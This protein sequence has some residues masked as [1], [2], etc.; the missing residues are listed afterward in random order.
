MGEHLKP[1][2]L[3]RCSAKQQLATGDAVSSPKTTKSEPKARQEL[4]LPGAEPTKESNLIDNQG[5][6]FGGEKKASRVLGR[7]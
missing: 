6:A 5:Q 2:L 1:L 7:K 4:T 3:Q